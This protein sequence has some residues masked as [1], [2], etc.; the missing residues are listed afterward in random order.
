VFGPQQAIG[1]L[2]TDKAGTGSF[3]ID[4]WQEQVP[5]M[6]NFYIDIAV[7]AQ[8]GGPGAGGYGDTYI[9][10]PFNLLQ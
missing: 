4:L 7:P 9:A 8:P 1:T 3:Q 5:A 10:G 6:G 2:T